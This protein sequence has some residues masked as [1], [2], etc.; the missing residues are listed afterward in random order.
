MSYSKGEWKER[1]V[2][3]EREIYI[4]SNGDNIVQEV[5]CRNVRHWNAPL[6]KAAPKMFEALLSAL[7]VMATLDQNVGWVKEIKQHFNNILN[8]ADGKAT[9]NQE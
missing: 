4:D 5:I 6:I 1:L 2:M 3:G 7:G 9:P 8:E